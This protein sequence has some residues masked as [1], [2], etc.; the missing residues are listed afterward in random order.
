VIELKENTAL[1]PT[2]SKHYKEAIY[3]FNKYFRSK[4]YI[5][6]TLFNTLNNLGRCLIKR[7]QKKHLHITI[8]PTK[9]KK[10]I[11]DKIKY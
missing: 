8:N 3:L 1:A 7:K 6:R 10:H 11:N 9:I 5:K 4:K 2:A